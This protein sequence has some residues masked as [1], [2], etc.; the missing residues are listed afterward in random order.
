MILSETI[1]LFLPRLRLKQAMQ[2]IFQ[3]LP[4]NIQVALQNNYLWFIY[5]FDIHHNSLLQLTGNTPRD[6]LHL[7][8]I[9]R[10]LIRVI[11]EMNLLVNRSKYP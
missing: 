10:E 4:L 6:H 5:L 2:L 3:L 7:Y 1:L 11:Q 9:S 8:A